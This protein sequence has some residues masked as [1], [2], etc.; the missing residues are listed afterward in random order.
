MPLMIRQIL[1]VGVELGNA[2]TPVALMGIPADEI[3]HV[4][5]FVPIGSAVT[6][7]RPVPLPRSVRDLP[8]TVSL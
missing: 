8:V 3:D 1:V 4:F 6:G 5:E 2:E 7:F